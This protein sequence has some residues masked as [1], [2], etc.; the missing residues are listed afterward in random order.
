MADLRD[1][2][3]TQAFSQGNT[4]EVAAA[5]LNRPPCLGLLCL[6]SIVSHGFLPGSALLGTL[7]SRPVSIP[8]VVILRRVLVKV[9]VVL[10]NTQARTRQSRGQSY[11][12]NG[13]YL[14]LH[15]NQRCPRQDPAKKVD[16]WLVQLWT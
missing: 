8:F 1:L 12:I 6:P 10:R 13:T 9:W 15:S 5:L 7:L 3:R 11:R 2:S 16:R 4:T 14:F